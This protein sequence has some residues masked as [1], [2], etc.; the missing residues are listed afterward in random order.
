MFVLTFAGCSRKYTNEDFANTIWIYESDN[1]QGFIFDYS[2]NGLLIVDNFTL[3]KS[4]SGD[5]LARA[6]GLN[7]TIYGEVQG[8]NIVKFNEK[9][10]KTPTKDDYF[11]IK[12]GKLQWV[13]NGQTVVTMNKSEYATIEEYVN[14]LGF[15]Y[16][17][18]GQY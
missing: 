17:G 8:N 4:F 15:E 10:L 9:N 7:A 18:E 16:V 5:S 6:P 11:L 3:Y 1:L 14:S 12:K 2:E 13:F